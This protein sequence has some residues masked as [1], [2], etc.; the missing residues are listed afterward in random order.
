VMFSNVRSLGLSLH[1]LA[2]LFLI[3]VVN[4]VWRIAWSERWDQIVRLFFQVPKSSGD[5]QILSIIDFVLL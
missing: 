1:G 2:A 4:V 5:K 3:D